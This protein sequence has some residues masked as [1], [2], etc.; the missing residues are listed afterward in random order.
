[1]PEK[2]KQQNKLTSLFPSYAPKPEERNL[3][4]A[5]KALAAETFA[6]GSCH[7]LFGPSDWVLHSYWVILDPLFL[8]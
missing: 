5:V 1:M 4:T 7:L 6:L 3:V 2:T 8:P